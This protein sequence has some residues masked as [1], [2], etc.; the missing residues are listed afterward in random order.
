MATV[1]LTDV[2]DGFRRAR[3]DAER[4]IALDPTLASGYL[5]LANTQISYD[6]DW[7]AANTCLSKATSL[8]PGSPEV[9]DMRP[10]LAWR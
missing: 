4:A 5:E 10:H 1:S 2:T 3:D 7:D 9:L 8:E 6:W